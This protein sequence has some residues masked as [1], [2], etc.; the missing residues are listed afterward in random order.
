MSDILRMDN[1]SKYF[2][3]VK[4]L[5]D[6]DFC[7][8]PG[9]VHALMGEN[10]AGKSTL[11][12]VLT[13][14]H[15]HDSGTILLNGQAINPSSPAE[16][17]A[18]GIS[19]IH[20]EVTMLEYLTVAEN[21]FIGRQ[22]MK[23]GRINWREINNRASDIMRRLGINIDVTLPL[24]TYPVAIRQMVSIARAVDLSCKVLV[25]DEPTSSLDEKEVAQLFDVVRKLRDQ[26]AG[27]VFI[28]HFLDQVYEISDRITVL[29]NGRQV[30]V[31]DTKSLP[32]IELV[33]H[34]LGKSVEDVQ[35]LFQ[36]KAKSADETQRN[37]FFRAVNISRS[38]AIKA[39]DLEI[40]D[41]EVLG[42]A[43]LLG[44]GRTEL[45][46][47]LFGADK[48]TSGRIEIDGKSIT[49]L[50]PKSAIE[51]RIGFSPEDRRT[52]AIIPDLSVADNIVLAVLKRI[53]PF[54]LISR[55]KQ[56]EI[57]AKYVETLNIATPSLDQPIKLLSGGNQQK[58]ILARWLASEPRLLIL[59]EPTRGIDVGAK[60][61]IESLIESL[62]KEGMAIVFISSELEEVVRRSDRVIVLRDRQQIA[63]LEGDAINE[64]NI[65]GLIAGGAANG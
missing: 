42:L 54:G 28:T 9:E 41:G 44:S 51:Q 62:S 1:I 59:D 31:F 5:Q 27:I 19:A 23:L 52:D 63:E 55:K 29:R 16:A 65:M 45:A 18:L 60:A 8:R 4:A 6:V 13:G 17:Q 49:K 33:G 48:P 61:E 40:K 46:R 24:G 53:S 11:I 37:V 34:M 43:G 38:G 25:M 32:K 30:G 10:G 12:K 35:T 56:R 36:E 7:V 58:V 3:G 57:A 22:P 14:V 39:L 21:I 64:Q 47:L 26:G 20:Q 15:P 2:P 50:S